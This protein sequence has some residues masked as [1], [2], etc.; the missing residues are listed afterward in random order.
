MRNRF[1]LLSSVL[2]VVCLGLFSCTTHSTKKNQR[3]TASVS[4]RAATDVARAGVLADDSD[5]LTI[6]SGQRPTDSNTRRL[7]GI[8]NNP[9]YTPLFDLVNVAKKSIDIEIYMMSDHAFRTALR[10]ALA[11]NVVIRIV[12]DPTP[13]GETCRYFNADLSVI[14]NT[15]APAIGAPADA[16]CVD[17]RRFLSEVRAAGGN[18]VAFDKQVMCGQAEVST[19]SRCFEHG[20]IVIADR[21]DQANQLALISTGNFNNSNLCVIEDKPGTCNRDYSYVTRDDDVISGLSKI[22][23]QDLNKI[24]FKNDRPELAGKMTVS[25]FTKAPLISFIESATQHLQVENQYMKDPDVNGALMAAAKRGVNVEMT[26][27]SDCSFSAPKG[28]VKDKLTQMY[29]DL[30]AAG[31]HLRFFT[32][33]MLQHQRKGYLHAKAIVADGARAWVGSTN[34]SSTSLDVNRE[35]GIFFSHPARVKYLSSI[36]SDDMANPLGETWQEAF[37][38]ARDHLS[39]AQKLDLP[40]DVNDASATEQ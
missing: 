10:N 17:Q 3:R 35:Y 34:G 16:D 6:W 21:G 25:P 19:T 8:Y 1:S 11:R 14:T 28:T 5:E 20:K 30:E 32:A 27:A 40:I 7:V 2:L 18:I 24:H 23:E 39:A 22:F 37:S 33:Q 36:M 38:C 4:G 31:V 26:L 12:K 9:Q 29:T 13:L 15:D